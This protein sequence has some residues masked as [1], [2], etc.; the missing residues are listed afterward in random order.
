MNLDLTWQHCRVL[1]PGRLPLLGRLCRPCAPGNDT[2]GH[3]PY[4]A[5]H[6]VHCWF[7]MC[8]FGFLKILCDDCLPPLQS[9]ET[10]CLL[11]CYKLVYQE[12]FFLLRGNHECSTLNRIY[13]F[14]DECKRRYNVSTFLLPACASTPLCRWSRPPPP[15]TSTLGTKVRLWRIFGDCFN[16]MPVAAVIG[17]K[18]FCT[19]GGLS[20]ELDSLSRI[21]EIQRPT[22]VSYHTPNATEKACA[23]TQQTHAASTNVLAW[24]CEIGGRYRARPPSLLCPNGSRA[25]LSLLARSPT[26][27]SS[28]TCC[29]RTPTPRYAA[30]ATTC[31]AS[32]TRS[33]TTLSPS[34]WPRTTSTSSAAPTRSAGVEAWQLEGP[35]RVRHASISL[36]QRCNRRS[37][38]IACPPP[39]L[40]LQVVEDG[41][42]FQAVR[43]LVT[44]FSAPNYC[45]ECALLAPPLACSFL[46]AENKLE[47][48]KHFFCAVAQRSFLSATAGEFDNAG[49]ILVVRSNM[50]CSFKILRPKEHTGRI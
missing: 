43:Q 19:H 41:Y 20:P 36:A 33:A 26:R 46:L 24:V 3:H 23:H 4:V 12:T 44:I 50:E 42:E 38:L 49:G 29:G 2:I 16:C 28:A 30:G 31:G 22:E 47:S 32:R 6:P 18:I 17:E 9:I 21:R 39:G 11:L 35:C 34:S 27:A 8:W 14:F 37:L 7:F 5:A 1:N 15:L 25:A 45:G 48:R 40:C 10:I 13:G